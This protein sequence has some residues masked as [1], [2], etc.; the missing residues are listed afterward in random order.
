M[1][2]RVPCRIASF[3]LSLG[4]VPTRAEAPRLA[5]LFILLNLLL[6][7]GLCAHV[8]SSSACQPARLAASSNAF[9][10]LRLVNASTRSPVL[11]STAHDLPRWTLPHCQHQRPAWPGPARCQRCQ[12]TYNRLHAR[13]LPCLIH[14]TSSGQHQE[15]RMSYSCSCL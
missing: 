4:R 9:G 11:Q 13:T 10:T 7:H 5:S 14:R 2:C 6:L 1:A 3:C 15:T 8:V 12:L